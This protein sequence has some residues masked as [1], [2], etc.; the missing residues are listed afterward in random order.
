[1]ETQSKRKSNQLFLKLD[2]DY[3]KDKNQDPQYRP[4]YELLIQYY[5]EK[6]NTEKQLEYI[7]KFCF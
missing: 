2:K 5:K 7:N 6:G 3:Y 4:A 1:L